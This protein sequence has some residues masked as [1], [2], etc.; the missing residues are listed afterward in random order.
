MNSQHL[1]AAIADV[2]VDDASVVDGVPPLTGTAC[3][4]CA[5]SDLVSGQSAALWPHAVLHRLVAPVEEVLDSELQRY[6]AEDAETRVDLV[7]DY[8]T[9]LRYAA[10]QIVDA[11]LERARVLGLAAS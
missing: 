3:G 1:I 4:R 6:V 2:W 7:D 8:R 11:A 5:D 10:R 9:S